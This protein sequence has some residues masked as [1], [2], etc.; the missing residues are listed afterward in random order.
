MSFWVYGL[1]AIAVAGAVAF[2][3]SQFGGAVA[4][5]LSQEAPSGASLA[6]DK[7]TLLV[8]IRNP[9][10]WK[11]TGVVE[12]A[13]LVTYSSPE[14]FLAAVRPHLKAGQRLG[15]ICRSGNRTSRAAM[16]IAPLV[17]FPVVDIQGGMNRVLGQGY[18]PV[19][20]TRE[21]GCKS[22]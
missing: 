19:K 10:E 22:C 1:A 7:S 2:G 21:R 13:L 16:Q 9:D 18:K 5:N 20:P 8:D 11:Q 14:A 15:L 3:V 6:A 17:D 12:G 4:E